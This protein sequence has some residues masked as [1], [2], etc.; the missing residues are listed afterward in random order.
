MVSEKVIIPRMLF[1]LI[2]ELTKCLDT[3]G[4]VET[5]LMELSKACD[6]LS[7]NFRIAK[8]AAYGC[9][10]TALKLIHYYLIH[11]L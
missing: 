5:V 8:L 1:K 6:C 2:K 3:S 11:R 4:V 10:N 9:D 7:H